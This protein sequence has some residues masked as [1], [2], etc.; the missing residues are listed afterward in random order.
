MKKK[1]IAIP[2]SI[3]A[4]CIL[5]LVAF[6]IFSPKCVKEADSGTRLLV[7]PVSGQEISIP[8]SYEPYI[9]YIK[10]SMVRDAEEKIAEE[11]AEYEETSGY[12]LTQD[13]DGYLCLCV[14]V[15]VNI[16]TESSESGCGISHEH[17]YF[18]Y[19]ITTKAFFIA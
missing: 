1:H 16:P 18:R 8:D 7:L 12:F 9:P 19:P 2:L 15:I 5:A 4:V 3:L 13:P 6:S 10:D 11:I 14:E 17:L